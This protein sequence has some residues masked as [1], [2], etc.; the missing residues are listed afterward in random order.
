MDYLHFDL[1]YV[2]YE[3]IH[4]TY[5]QPTKTLAKSRVFLYDQVGIVAWR[6]EKLQGVV[7]TL[8]GFCV[9]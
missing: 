3:A 9:D 6:V 1:S 8:L 5:M 7:L 2:Y 4:L